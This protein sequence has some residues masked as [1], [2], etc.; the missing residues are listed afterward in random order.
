MSMMSKLMLQQSYENKLLHAKAQSRR[1]FF[2][3]FCVQ[4]CHICPCGQFIHS[5]SQ[6]S[7]RHSLSDVT[8]PKNL[9]FVLKVLTGVLQTI[10]LVPQ[11]SVLVDDIL[12]SHLQIMHFTTA[13]AF[14]KCC[15]YYGWCYWYWC[16]CNLTLTRLIF[17]DFQD[18][19]PIA[20]VEPI[21]DLSSFELTLWQFHVQKFRP[22]TTHDGKHQ[23]R[24][25]KSLKT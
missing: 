21:Q 13:I 24:I 18:F 15:C 22:W 23:T 20:V 14:T 7:C 6:G 8:L 11:P 19:R 16:C 5:H 25:S 1:L 9:H 10:D 12:M 4:S 2:I 3:T 17:L